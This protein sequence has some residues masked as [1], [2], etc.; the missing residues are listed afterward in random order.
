MNET[1]GTV[2]L[3]SSVQQREVGTWISL[4]VQHVTL[5]PQQS[6]TVSFQILVPKNAPAG[7]HVGGIVAADKIKASTNKLNYLYHAFLQNACS[8]ITHIHFLQ[9]LLL[10]QK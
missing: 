1:S 3:A 5:A 6:Q 7:Q 4:S 9:Y 10:A 2:F 8:N